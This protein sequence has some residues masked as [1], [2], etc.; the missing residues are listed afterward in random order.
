MV[1]GSTFGV[2]EPALLGM[3]ASLGRCEG[4]NCTVMS[5]LTPAP[6]HNLSCYGGTYVPNWSPQPCGQVP[7]VDV[8]QGNIDPHVLGGKYIQGYAFDPKSPREPLW[9]RISVDGSVVD[10]ILANISRPDLVKAGIVPNPEHGIRW[11]LPPLQPGSEHTLAFDV[12]PHDQKQ[13]TVYP[14]NGSPFQIK[15]PASDSG[16][17]EQP[18]VTALDCSLGG[19]CL[20]GRCRC[21][22]AW[23]GPNCSVL[24]L[25]AARNIHAFERPSNQSSWGGSVIRDEDG[26][27]HMYAGKNR[28]Q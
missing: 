24:N 4:K 13:G 7:W 3:A 5:A 21:Y 12:Y 17:A 16:P 27:Y 15:A 18:C 14:L 11:T 28:V 19:Q 25:V 23:V 20:G 26:L 2:D 8:P 22:S 10:T 1:K 6:L 9:V